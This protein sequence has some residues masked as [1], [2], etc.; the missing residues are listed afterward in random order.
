MRIESKVRSPFSFVLFPPGLSNAIKL[1]E[2]L[3][4]V[5]ALRLLTPALLRSP[6]LSIAGD[7]EGKM[8][9]SFLT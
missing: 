8:G 1:A 2:A 9:M 3:A 4:V 5:D 6:T 7:K